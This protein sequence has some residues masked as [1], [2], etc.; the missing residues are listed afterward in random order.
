MAYVWGGNL[1]KVCAQVSILTVLRRSALFDI[2]GFGA[3]S[4]ITHLARQ[5]YG[6]LSGGR[7]KDISEEK[8][9]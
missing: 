2:T 6:E 7:P 1:V 3:V 4:L 5:G 8:S 9:C